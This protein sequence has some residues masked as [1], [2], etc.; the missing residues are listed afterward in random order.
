MVLILTSYTEQGG[1]GE[2]EEGGGGASEKEKQLA[3][4]SHNLL[5]KILSE[6]VR[7]VVSIA[8]CS[9]P[10]LLQTISQTI[11]NSVHEFVVELLVRMFEP[12]SAHSHL[13]RFCLTSDPE[14]CPPHYSS[15]AVRATLDYLPS[16]YGNTAVGTSFIR[17]LSKKKVFHVLTSANKN[18]SL[19]L[20]LG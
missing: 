12:P 17:L 10:Y 1:E 3:S 15:H 8:P 7:C 9:C 20:S 18:I 19:S 14:P 11:Q 5:T 6:E 13:T 16:C 2:G 4:N